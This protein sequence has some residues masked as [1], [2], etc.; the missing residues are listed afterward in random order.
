[1][2][3]KSFFTSALW[4]FGIGA[5]MLS[6]GYGGNIVVQADVLELGSQATKTLTVA[7]A[8]GAGLIFISALMFIWAGTARK[9]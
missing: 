8:V 9:K 3:R 7:I 5:L 2:K 1:M 6:L 4:M